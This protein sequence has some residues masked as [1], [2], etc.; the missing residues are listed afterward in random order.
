ML[1]I[2]IQY[3]LCNSRQKS[4]FSTTIWLSDR[5]LL[6]CNQQ[7]T[8]L[9]AVVDNNYGAHAFTAQT[10]THQWVRWREEQINC[11]QR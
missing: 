8:V 3:R 7:L 1:L 4:R 11:T 2:V 10:A 9:G 6:N 5:W